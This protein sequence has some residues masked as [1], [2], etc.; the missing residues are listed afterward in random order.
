MKK[1]HYSYIFLAI[2]TV[3]LCILV[4]SHGRIDYVPIKEK[5]R[6]EK[7]SP[8]HSDTIKALILYHAADYFV[9][10]G[11][12]IGFQYDLIKQMGKDLERPVEIS[13]ETDPDKVFLK[14]FSNE[15]DIVGFD[16]DK[17]MFPSE[18]L[19]Q[20]D[21]HSY[22]YP[23]LLMRKGTSLDTNIKR[24]VHAAS[25][26]DNRID[27]K[28]LKSLGTWELQ[29]DVDVTVEDDFVFPRI[30]NQVMNR[31][32]KVICKECGIDTPIRVTW[33]KGHE[34][35]DE[36]H[37]KYELIGTH[38]A[39]RTFVCNALMMGIAPSVVMSW[40]G[41]SCYRNMQPYIDIADSAKAKAM[42]IFDQKGAEKEKPGAK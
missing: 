22:T 42:L 28:D 31:E 6:L 25:K 29:H 34:R 18:Y 7:K 11:S 13:I 20:S 19:V 1:K 3:L 10:Q 23:V 12:V 27:F 38:C 14:C 5:L 9:Y 39:R 41:H 32:L 8:E 24:V 40:T 33:Y 37:P 36:I 30:A 26:Y 17:T 16:F 35:V 2:A 15:Y 21:A 4:V